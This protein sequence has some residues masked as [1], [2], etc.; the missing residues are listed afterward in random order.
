[1]TITSA[2]INAN[3]RPA[4]LAILFAIVPK[5]L[6]IAVG[7]LFASLPF[8]GISLALACGVANNAFL[9]A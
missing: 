9:R 4:F 7:L 3:G 6:F 2:V 5:A 8:I 1:M